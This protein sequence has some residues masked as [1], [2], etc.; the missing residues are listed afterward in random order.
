VLPRGWFQPGRIIEMTSDRQ[1][2]VRLV[3]LLS[4]GSN[5]E[6]ISFAAA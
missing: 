3:R 2:P 6:Q 1:V 5:F 4:Q